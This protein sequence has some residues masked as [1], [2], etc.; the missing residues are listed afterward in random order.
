MSELFISIIER[1]KSWL[2]KGVGHN[3]LFARI[4][5]QVPD[6][7]RSILTGSGALHV[8]PT[9]LKI[10]ILVPIIHVYFPVFNYWP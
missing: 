9:Q 2:E 4:T 6:N 1:L 7:T 3:H 8:I 10:Q 5:A